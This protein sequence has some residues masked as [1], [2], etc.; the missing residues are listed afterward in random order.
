MVVFRVAPLLLG[1]LG[2]VQIVLA[3][4]P[5]NGWHCS[6]E[7]D[8]YG[9]PMLGWDGSFGYITGLGIGLV[10]LY[11]HLSIE[12]TTR[13][14]LIKT[15]PA[16]L[17]KGNNEGVSFIL[18]FYY[19]NGEAPMNVIANDLS[20]LV[21]V[22]TA[23]KKYIYAL[24]AGF[25]GAAY[26]E[27][28]GG[29]LAPDYDPGWSSTVRA[30]KS[31]VVQELKKTGLP[32]LIRYP[33]DIATYFPDDP[34][35]G[36]HD[37]CILANGPGGHDAGTFSKGGIPWP[38]NDLGAAMIY[39]Q[40]KIQGIRGGESCSDAGTAPDCPALLTFVKNF[41]IC[42]LNVEPVLHVEQVLGCSVEDDDD[43]D[44]DD[45]DDDDQDNNNND[46]DDQDD[47]D[48]DG[49]DQDDDGPKVGVRH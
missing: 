15:L 31:Y 47:D 36:W 27:W 3:A 17:A 24:Q 35:I 38:E 41:K 5:N 29:V 10:R 33:R 49:D 39:S 42:F 1:L 19:D 25:L 8:Q 43:D 28:W 37:D 2:I 7:V 16:L 18:R 26:G 9:N 45:D 34:Q 4:S 23:N 40:H 6:R 30:A 12:T 21:P 20:Q 46:N 11:V 14:Q 44:Q 22:V 13:S 48:D 32:I